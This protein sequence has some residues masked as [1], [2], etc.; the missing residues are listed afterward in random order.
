LSSI[1]SDSKLRR[2][3]LMEQ[4]D[5]EYFKNLIL[6]KQ[7]EIFEELNM[8]DLKES[9]REEPGGKAYS[10]HMA[11]VGSDS[12]EREKSF[13][14][15]SIEGDILTE[16]NEALEQIENGTYG[17]CAICSEPI[18]PNRLE[19]IPYTKLCLECKSKEERI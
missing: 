15:A 19:A 14:V 9:L 13:L 3:Q 18:H 4:L 17:I 10:F 5:I 16:L 1:N 2:I 8:G 11:D 6:E 7:Q 12:N